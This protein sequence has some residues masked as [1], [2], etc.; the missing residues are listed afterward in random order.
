[1]ESRS[2]A[3]VQQSDP[4]GKGGDRHWFWWAGG[5]YVRPGLF[6]RN[7][8][9]VPVSD[10]IIWPPKR[11]QLRRVSLTTGGK[12]HFAYVSRLGLLRAVFSK[13]GKD[14]YL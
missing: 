6:F 8:R 4:F 12:D 14:V 5:S 7:R 1:M 2:A 3:Q 10:W 11:S 13:P 9:I